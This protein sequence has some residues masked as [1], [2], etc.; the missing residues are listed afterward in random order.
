[1][2]GPHSAVL[3]AP[4][5]DSAAESMAAARLSRHWGCSLKLCLKCPCCGPSLCWLWPPA[6]FWWSGGC[7]LLSPQTGPSKWSLREAG[8]T[9]GQPWAAFPL[10]STSA[11]LWAGVGFV[12]NGTGYPGNLGWLQEELGTTLGVLLTHTLLPSTQ[13]YP[14]PGVIQV[15]SRG[16]EANMAGFTQDGQPSRRLTMECLPHLRTQQ[17]WAGK[18]PKRWKTG[19]WRVSSWMWVACYGV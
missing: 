15:S 18:C 13:A 9:S 2:T 6:S 12:R 1:M 3:G 17:C 8:G 10:R 5:K 4:R 14:R 11:L 19:R 16:S 7:M